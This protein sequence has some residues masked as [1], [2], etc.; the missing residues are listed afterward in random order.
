MNLLATIKNALFGRTPAP[1]PLPAPLAEEPTDPPLLSIHVVQPTPVSGPTDRI[2]DTVAASNDYQLRLAREHSDVIAGMRFCATIQ[3]RTPARVLRRHGEVHSDLN[4]P[5]PAIAQDLWEGIWTQKTRTYKELGFDVPDFLETCTMA[6][7]IG[8]IP[9]DGGDYL[10]FLLA[11]RGVVEAH[12]RI[13]ER[14]TKLRTLLLQPEYEKFTGAHWGADR[15]IDRFF[16]RF[17][18]SI[19]KLN[20][21]SVSE[22][23]RLGLNTPNRI[24]AASDAEL[25]AIPGIGPAKLEIIRKHCAEVTTDRDAARV[26]RVIR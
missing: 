18:D 21:I 4:Q 26:D 13:E 12:E 1:A 20:S 25:L 2:I 7:E 3:L 14:I 5:L 15:I 24:A 8:P 10:P 9:Y 16:P 6:S 11:V 17:I 22:L 23:E 19:P